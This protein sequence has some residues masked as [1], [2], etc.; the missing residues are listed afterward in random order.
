[1]LLNTLIMLQSLY[2]INEYHHRKIFKNLENLKISKCSTFS[3]YFRFLKQFRFRKKYIFFDIY[4]F[5]DFE[6]K[7][8]RFFQHFQISDFRKILKGIDEQN[9]TFKKNL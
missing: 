6:K 3:F 4:D 7:N 1:M 2:T 9:I 8:T 5:F